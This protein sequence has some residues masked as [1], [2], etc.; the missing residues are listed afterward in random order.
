MFIEYDTNLS[1]VAFISPGA[2]GGALK[3]AVGEYS[4]CC[5]VL[6]T[7]LKFVEFSTRS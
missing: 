5:C 4:V 6:F 1:I 3:G 2:A 7:M